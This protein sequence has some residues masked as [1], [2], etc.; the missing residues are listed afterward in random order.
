MHT[1][2]IC[3]DHALVREAMIGTIK[4]GWPTV[5]ISE[6]DNFPN[7][8][9]HAKRAPDLCIAD[10]VMPGAQPFE[11][12]VGIMEASPST[13]ILV[14]TGTEDDSLLMSLLRL[15]VSGFAPK[16]ASAAV[17]HAAIGL[18]LAGGRYL[19][20]RV[21]DIA[22][23]ENHV[24]TASKNLASIGVTA[25]QYEVLRLVAVGYSNKEIAR[26]LGMAPT[27]VKTHIENL[28]I[29]LKATNRTEAS[30]KAR[31]LGLI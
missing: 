13:A 20:P 12:V 16:S 30:T 1:C 21:A 26:A 6:A 29:A 4:M 2:L 24:K 8:W 10:L 28:F 3:D 22:A 31:L 25:R 19:P 14:F 5:V 9:E 23:A 11:G 18:I 7:A 27:T 17:I 15:G